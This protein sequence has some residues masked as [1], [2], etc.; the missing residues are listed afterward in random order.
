MD[1]KDP[2]GSKEI[3]DLQDPPVLKEIGGP[4]D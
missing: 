2:M 1:H 4:P 3:Q